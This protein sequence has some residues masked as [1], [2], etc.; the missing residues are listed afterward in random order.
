PPEMR[1]N[2]RAARSVPIVGACSVLMFLGRT[3]ASDYCARCLPTGPWRDNMPGTALTTRSFVNIALGRVSEPLR[4]GITDKLEPHATLSL[5]SSSARLQIPSL[6]L[7]HKFCVHRLAYA[8]IEAASQ[9][10]FRFGLG[11]ASQKNLECFE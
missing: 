1:T 2:P 11:S 6:G 7:L 5:R 8:A 3:S 9:S 10:N 4:D